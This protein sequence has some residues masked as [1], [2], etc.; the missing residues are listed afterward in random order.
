MRKAIQMAVNNATVMEM[1][2]IGQGQVAENHHV[3]P[4]HPEYAELPP[5]EVNPEKAK[6]MLV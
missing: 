6:Q 5:L 1:A 3:C 4:L 2:I